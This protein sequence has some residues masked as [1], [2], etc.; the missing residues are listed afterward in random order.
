ME[1]EVAARKYYGAATRARVSG[2]LLSAPRTGEQ[3]GIISPS[4]ALVLPGALS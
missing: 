3:I 1:E 4:S 2:A